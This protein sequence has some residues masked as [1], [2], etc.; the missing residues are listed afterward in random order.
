MVSS[1]RWRRNRLQ[2]P[3]S[4]KW[5]HRLRRRRLQKPRSQKWLQFAAS[6]NL[7]F[8]QTELPWIAHG[9]HHLLSIFV[10]SKLLVFC[11]SGD[12][13]VISTRV[14]SV[15]GLNNLEFCAVLDRHFHGKRPRGLRFAKRPSVGTWLNSA[16]KKKALLQATS[17]QFQTWTLSN[18]NGIFTQ[19]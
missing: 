14:R 12:S 11:V 17:G 3:R 10:D 13:S 6:E 7:H 4:Q 19:I 18:G 2:K 5:L 15:Q 9:L 1:P 8:F 16:P